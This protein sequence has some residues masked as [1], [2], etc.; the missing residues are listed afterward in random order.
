MPTRATAEHAGEVQVR[1]DGCS[2]AD[3]FAEAARA[4]A[5]LMGTPASEAPGVWQRV[6]LTA[7]DQD[8]LL[9][10]WL[11]ELIARTE[12]DHLLYVDVVVDELDERRL[13][14]WIRGVPIGETGTSV[15]AATEGLHIG[16]GPRG[17]S[18]SLVLDV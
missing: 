12:N 10:T 17:P 16:S 6:T 13:G 4:L 18:A 15:K 7:R 3:L 9:V 11:N 5:D 2:L 1:I 8:S 14:A